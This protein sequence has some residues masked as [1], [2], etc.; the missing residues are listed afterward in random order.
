MRISTSS[1]NNCATP[2]LPLFEAEGT[3]LEPSASATDGSKQAKKCRMQQFLSNWADNFGSGHS[4]D[5]AGHRDF[6]AIAAEFENYQ[7]DRC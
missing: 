7:P 3:E 4:V 2:V 6:A 1:K 5:A